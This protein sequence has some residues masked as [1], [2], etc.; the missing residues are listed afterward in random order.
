ME[1][2]HFIFPTYDLQGTK[3]ET[4][5]NNFYLSHHS[6]G[7]VSFLFD[8]VS[9]SSRP[10]DT[11]T[12]ILDSNRQIKAPFSQPKSVKKSTRFFTDIL[13]CLGQKI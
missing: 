3:E 1:S 12:S 2:S 4:K 6:S 13:L 5:S 11:D 10:F 8:Y 7:E 9:H